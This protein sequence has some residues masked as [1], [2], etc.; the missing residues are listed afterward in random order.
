MR[1]SSPLDLRRTR[2]RRRARLNALSLTI[3][4]RWHRAV[5]IRVG[6][7]AGIAYPR[8]GDYVA[9]ALHQAARESWAPPTAVKCSPRRTRL[10]PPVRLRP[11][12]L[13]GTVPSASGISSGLFGWRRC[14]ARMSASTNRLGARCPRRGPQPRAARKRPSLGAQPTSTPFDGRSGLGTSSR[15]SGR[16]G[17]GR[18]ASWLRWVCRWRRHGPTACGSSTCRA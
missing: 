15:W 5:R 1:S 12:D 11:C 9:L 14:W 8:A 18:R 3:R 4:G 17:W 6:V 16:V 7:H 2:C 10:P 13:R